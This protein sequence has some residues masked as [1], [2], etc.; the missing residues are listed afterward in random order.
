MTEKVEGPVSDFL[1]IAQ[2]YGQPVAHGLDP[3]AGMEGATHMQRVARL[4]AGHGL[5]QGHANALVAHALA[6]AKGTP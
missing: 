4:K 1:S 3:I 6:K 5:G 2:T